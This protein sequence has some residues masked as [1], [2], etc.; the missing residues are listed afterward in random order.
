MLSHRPG[1]A[2]LA[3]QARVILAVLTVLCSLLQV[4]EGF[5]ACAEVSEQ[6]AVFLVGDGGALR[7]DVNGPRR[8]VVIPWDREGQEEGVLSNGFCNEWKTVKNCV[9]TPVVS[10]RTQSALTCLW[11]P[12]WYEIKDYI[13]RDSVAGWLHV[14]MHTNSTNYMP[15]C[16]VCALCLPWDHL[17]YIIVYSQL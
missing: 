11:V 3:W 12:V 16:T 5:A 2:T 1:L 15:A 17:L 9:E 10:N 6:V 8:A 7:A 4:A 13:F 14:I